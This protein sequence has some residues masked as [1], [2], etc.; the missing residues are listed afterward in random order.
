MTTRAGVNSY[1]M[2]MQCRCETDDM[3]L[4]GPA[5]VCSLLELRERKDVLVTFLAASVA[6]ALALTRSG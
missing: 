6:T 1:T 2:Y 3:C 4:W 5:I